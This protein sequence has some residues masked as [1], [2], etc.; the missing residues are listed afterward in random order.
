MTEQDELTPEMLKGI[1][2]G[3]LARQA[4]DIEGTVEGKK[5]LPTKEGKLTTRRHDAPG[6]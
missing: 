3:K 2:G 6:T 1:F 4:G 5:T